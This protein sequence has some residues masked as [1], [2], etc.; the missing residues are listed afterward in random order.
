[1]VGE[2]AGT[3]EGLEHRGFGLLRLQEERV[4]IV[5]AGHQD[6][7]GAGADAADADHLAGDLAE[8]EGVEQLLAVALEAGAIGVQHLLEQLL[9]GAAT[10][11]PHE[12]LAGDEQRRF[13]AESDLAVDGLGQLLQ[14]PQAVL[15]AR[16]ADSLADP[17]QLLRVVVFDRRQRLFDV[18][19]R[20]PDVE[21]ALG[22]EVAH[23]LAVGANH[24]PDDLHPRLAPQA[25]FA[26]G[27][28]EAGAEALDVP[29]PR[30]G[31]RLVEVVEVEDEAP[32]GGGEGAEVGEVGIAAGLHAQARDRG[33]RQV[34]SHH[35]GGAAVEGERR[36]RHSP[37]ADRDQLR[38]PRARLP[39][40]DLDRVLAVLGRAPAGVAG[41]RRA[42]TR[43]LSRGSA[44]GDVHTATVYLR[45]LSEKG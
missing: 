32:V 10:L 36:G 27:D 16:L 22:G 44:F 28:R 4:A 19:A 31:Q 33:P 3:G 11:V 40:E 21:V 26:G 15:G 17:L 9:H 34:G 5:G 20:V 12:L 24:G 38:D 18:E 39:L 41:A 8:A 14:R 6:H 13:A 25:V 42:R 45:R 30:P 43:R 35:R 7:P 23:R 37:V 29:L 1:M 2:A